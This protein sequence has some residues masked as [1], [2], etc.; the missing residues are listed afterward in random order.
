MLPILGFAAG[1]AMPAWAESNHIRAQTTPAPARPARAESPRIETQLA[2][3][4]P[5]RPSL[6]GSATGVPPGYYQ[7]ILGQP[8][9]NL[10]LPP[11]IPILSPWPSTI[12]VE[13]EPAR[14]QPPIIVVQQVQAPPPVIIQQAPPEREV[15]PPS[16]PVPE[17]PARP[18]PTAPQN[19]HFTIAPA[20]AFLRLDG[21]PLGKANE[22]NGAAP[23]SLAPGVYI[24]QVEHPAHPSQ[25]LVFG[26][27]ESAVRVDIDLANKDP[28]YRA[29]VQ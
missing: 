18:R 24:L 25:R 7:R 13:R 14:E 19:V 6:M 9:D 17:E 11:S 16:A 28:M 21:R 23:M 2:A 5:Y 8:A 3:P 10:Y 26:V 12:F 22:L 20:D 4:N 27:S 29:R 15:E 1:L